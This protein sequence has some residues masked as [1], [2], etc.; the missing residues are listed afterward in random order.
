MVEQ[1][2]RGRSASISCG[3]SARAALLRGEIPTP[4]QRDSESSSASSNAGTPNSVDENAFEDSDE[5]EDCGRAICRNSTIT[6]ENAAQHPESRSQYE[7]P[8]KVEEEKSSKW[9]DKL[10]RS[11]KRRSS[12]TSSTSTRASSSSQKSSG[13]QGNVVCKSAMSWGATLVCSWPCFRHL[14]EVVS[15]EEAERYVSEKG[16]RRGTADLK[17]VPEREED[18]WIEETEYAGGA[19]VR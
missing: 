19:G 12:S 2:P 14:D 13:G 18:Q 1:R 5:E 17:V 16:A 8:G 10:K 6:K 3:V 9:S 4:T 7:E 11:L 15:N